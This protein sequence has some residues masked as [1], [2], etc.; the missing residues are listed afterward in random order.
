M[1][2]LTLEGA[3]KYL[4]QDSSYEDT[5][6]D[7]FALAAES[8]CRDTAR[9]TQS[10]WDAIASAS[11][12]S[13]SITINGTE[14]SGDEQVQLREVIKVAALYALGYLYEHRTEADHH[15]LIMTL[16][17]LLSSIREGVF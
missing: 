16:R 6:I 4:R 15:D 5:L 3:K 17:F 13:A 10:Q 9:M 2:I 8:E 11:E 7:G 12:S 1:R 14:Y